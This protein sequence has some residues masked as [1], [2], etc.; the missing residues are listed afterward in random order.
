MLGLC[1]QCQPCNTFQWRPT[2]MAVQTH[3]QEQELEDIRRSLAER[4]KFVPPDLRAEEHDICF[5]GKMIRTRS[6]KN[7]NLENGW[8][9]KSLQSNA[10]WL[11]SIK[12]EHI[13][14][15][16]KQPEDTIGHCRFER[17]SG[18]AWTK[19]GA[20]A[21]VWKYNGCLGFLLWLFKLQLQLN[22]EWRKLRVP[23][24]SSHTAF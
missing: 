17:T 21:F 9:W 8:R 18:H 16:H 15:K 13:S 23:R 20:V 7:E 12:C 10:P 2:K 24:H 6:S 11:V 1:K 3:F 4:M 19:T 5:T 22:L 14:S